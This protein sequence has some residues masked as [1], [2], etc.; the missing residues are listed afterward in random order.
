[1]NSLLGGRRAAAGGRV[2]GLH[3]G[4]RLHADHLRPRVHDRAGVH[5]DRGAPPSS[6]GRRAQKI[7]SLSIGGPEVHVHQSGCADVRVPDD[8]TL[9]ACLRREVD[10]LPSSGADFYRGDHGPRGPGAA[11]RRATGAAARGPPRGVRRV[12]G[13]G[14]AVRPVP[15]LGSHAGV[16]AGD[17]LRDRARGRSVR[18]IRGQPAGLGRRSGP[19]G[20][21]PAGVD[22]L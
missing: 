21:V 11:D 3:R 10:R 4:R 15:V 16:G 20:V 8:D 5:G 22:P 13:A 7:T 19:A 18:R 12:R 1:M 2:R 17:D 9:I 14:A 6:K